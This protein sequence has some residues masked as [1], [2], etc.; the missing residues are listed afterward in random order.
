MFIW[1][2]KEGAWIPI[3]PEEYVIGINFRAKEL[4]CKGT[5]LIR[6]DSR[7][8]KA[9]LSLRQEFDEPLT[10]N[11]VCRETLH[12]SSVGGHKK[13]LH[14]IY[15]PYHTCN[16]TMAWDISVQGWTWVKLSRLLELMR[17]TKWS[18]GHG[19]E[20]RDGMAH[21]FVHGDRRYDIGLP[22]KEFY[23]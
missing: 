4:A 9:A 16:G 10:L 23:Y 5:G 17:E 2:H 12:N 13:S 3:D 8:S 19:Y 1:D 22:P 21:G 7:F 18:I 6:L 14:L 15:N 20:L 11:S